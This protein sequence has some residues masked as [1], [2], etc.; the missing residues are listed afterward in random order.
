MSRNGTPVR[1]VPIAAHGTHGD[2]AT[3]RHAE[4]S[5]PTR[6]VTA[7]DLGDEDALV[8]R[9]VRRWWPAL[10][11]LA[12]IA[13]VIWAASWYIARQPTKADVLELIEAKAVTKGEAK[14]T[15]LDLSPYNAD[16]ATLGAVVG[17]LGK[18][19]DTLTQILAAIAS[20]EAKYSQSEE[21]TRRRL[22]Q[23]ERTLRRARD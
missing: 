12:A 8:V 17:Q 5:A 19:N 20:L 1:G 11:A 21:E 16:R 14:Q 13:G 3:E 4:G 15:I 7:S 9:L 2:L 6:A 23:L 10:G 18:Q 22:D